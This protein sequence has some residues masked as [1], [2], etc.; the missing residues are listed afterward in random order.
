M[1]SGPNVLETL[2]DLETT[3]A[4]GASTIGR[5]KLAGVYNLSNGRVAWA[6]QWRK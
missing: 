3:T 4:E 2:D 6:C 1:R 5:P